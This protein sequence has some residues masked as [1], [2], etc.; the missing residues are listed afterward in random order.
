MLAFYSR[1]IFPIRRS[2]EID[3]FPIAFFLCVRVV[4]CGIVLRMG[5][6]AAGGGVKEG[7]IRPLVR[8]LGRV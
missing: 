2:R 5:H 6:L 4:S 7:R 1:R 3:R 8:F